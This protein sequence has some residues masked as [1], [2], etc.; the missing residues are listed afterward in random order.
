MRRQWIAATLA[1]AQEPPYI[2]DFIQLLA[3][4]ALPARSQR[5]TA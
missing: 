1:A 2:A 5:E 3:E 4:R